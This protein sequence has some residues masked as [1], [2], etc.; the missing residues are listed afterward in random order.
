MTT[1]F[2]GEPLF[3]AKAKGAAPLRRQDSLRHADPKLEVLPSLAWRG[4]QRHY[5]DIIIILMWHRGTHL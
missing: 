1:E 3:S 4:I 5:A 2:S